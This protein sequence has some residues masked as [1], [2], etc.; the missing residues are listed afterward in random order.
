[1]SQVAGWHVEVEFD[2]NDHRTRSAAMLRL[3]DGT[4]LRSRAHATRHPSDPNEARIGEEFAG[5][6]A[7]KELA[8]QLEAKG[9]REVDALHTRPPK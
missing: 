8:E 9:Q 1:M 3:R 2:E 7:L 6:R 5:A 4:E